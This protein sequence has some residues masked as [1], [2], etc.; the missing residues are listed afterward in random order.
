MFIDVYS[1]V[2]QGTEQWNSLKVKRLVNL[3]ESL[4]NLTEMLGKRNETITAG[5]S[6][7][8]GPVTETRLLLT[9]LLANMF[10]GIQWSIVP[11]GQQFN[12]HSLST[13]LCHNDQGTQS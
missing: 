1:K 12:I 9:E 3:P 13:F 6:Y 2:T 8:F 4:G 5:P 7:R 11:M 10:L